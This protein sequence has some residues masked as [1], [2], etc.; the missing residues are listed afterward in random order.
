MSKRPNGSGTINRQGYVVLSENRSLV[1]DHIKI[2]EQ[3]LGKKLPEGSQVHHVDG[4]P[5]NNL[6]TNLV[7]CQDQSY[8]KL[9]HRR[10]RALR[11]CGNPDYVKCRHCGRYQHPIKMVKDGP[12]GYSH[13]E[14]R[15]KHRRERYKEAKAR[16]KSV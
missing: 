15:S 5:S 11:D 10:T 16:G 2:A 1:Y 8:H 9:L 13:S 7:I 6:N 3:A 12:R 14:C 4:N